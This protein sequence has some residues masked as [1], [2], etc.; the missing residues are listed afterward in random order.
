MDLKTVADPS[1]FENRLQR[2]LG[3]GKKESPFMLDRGVREVQKHFET[4]RIDD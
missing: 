1:D 3:P 2:L 4:D